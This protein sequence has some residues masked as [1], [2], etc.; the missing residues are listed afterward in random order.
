MLQGVVMVRAQE[1]QRALLRDGWVV[2]HGHSFNAQ[3]HSQTPRNHVVEDN[4]AG[5]RGGGKR[6]VMRLSSQHMLICADDRCTDTPHRGL[7]CIVSL[8]KTQSLTCV[9][10]SDRQ[11]TS[12]NQK[13]GSK[14]R[15][16]ASAED[17]RAQRAGD[18][19]STLHAEGSV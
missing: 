19:L 6:Q 13:H 9:A 14:R 17:G 5:G 8:L 11:T 2:E 10:T 12:N 4:G 18:L 3:Q 16:I 1:Q 7:E 15:G